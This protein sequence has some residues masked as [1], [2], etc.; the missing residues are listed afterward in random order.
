MKEKLYILALTY[1]DAIDKMKLIDNTNSWLYD[2]RND[3]GFEYDRRNDYF[4]INNV[5]KEFKRIFKKDFMKNDK[6]QV[7]PIDRENF[8]IILSRDFYY[9]LDMPMTD[10]FLELKL[11]EYQI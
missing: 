4:D 3:Y 10:L 9:Y 8:N 7:L 2:G 11:I 1:K 6:Y 5:K